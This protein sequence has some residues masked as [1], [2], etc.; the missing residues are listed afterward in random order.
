[1]IDDSKSPGIDGYNARFFKKC[2]STVKVD[3]YA[4]V[5]DFFDG[6]ANISSWNGTLITLVS[7]FTYASKVHDFRPISYCTVVYNIIAKVLAIRLQSILPRIVSQAQTGFVPGRS[8]VD[9][10]LLA[11]E[12]I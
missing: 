8:I 1:M 12:L 9:N 4:A 7:K 2:W 10:V 3:I 6:K 5:M 11:S